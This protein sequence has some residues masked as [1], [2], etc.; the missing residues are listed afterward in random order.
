MG[1][2]TTTASSFVVEANGNNGNIGGPGD[3]PETGLELRYLLARA[4]GRYGENEFFG[5]ACDGRHLLHHI[6]LGIA[7]DGNATDP[8]EESTERC[9]K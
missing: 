9:T 8:P 4:F 5:A 6:V 1:S 3:V 2:P 7:V